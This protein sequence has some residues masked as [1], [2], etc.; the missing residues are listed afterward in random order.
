M[1]SVALCLLTACPSKSD[2]ETAYKAAASTCSEFGVTI[3]A[4]ASIQAAATASASP[5]STATSTSAVG[6]IASSDCD[7]ILVEKGVMVLLGGFALG[8]ALIL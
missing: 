3:P 6:K 2:Q 5:S 4:M 1:K 7:A 8:A